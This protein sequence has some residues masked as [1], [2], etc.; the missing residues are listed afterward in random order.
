MEMNCQVSG[1]TLW[2]LGCK[3]PQFPIWYE[4]GWVPGPLRNVVAKKSLFTSLSKLSP[5]KF[6]RNWEL[7]EDGSSSVWVSHSVG[8]GTTSVGQRIRESGKEVSA[9]YFR[10][11]LMWRWK[12]TSPTKRRSVLPI[13]TL[14]YPRR[15]IFS[16]F[17]RVCKIAKSDY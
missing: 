11:L 14:P 1:I 5:P 9:S 10:G 16:V 13:D 8:C 7:R 3:E 4:G 6:W 2:S 17:R 12:Q 15:H